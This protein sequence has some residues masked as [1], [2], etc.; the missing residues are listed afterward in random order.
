M[1]DYSDIGKSIE[2]LSREELEHLFDALAEQQIEN[3]EE[4]MSFA[5]TV[6]TIDLLLARPKIPVTTAKDVK[7]I[8]ES[9]IDIALREIINR[10][11][12][13]QLRPL[14]SAISKMA[15]ITG[16][17]AIKMFRPFAHHAVT[18]PARKPTPGESDTA[19]GEDITIFPVRPV[20]YIYDHNNETFVAAAQTPLVVSGLELMPSRVGVKAYTVA[21]KTIADEPV[22]FHAIT[23]DLLVSIATYLSD[24][25]YGYIEWSKGN[26][27]WYDSFAA[28][29]W[30]DGAIASPNPAT[31][32]AIDQIR[33]MH[34]GAYDTPQE[35]PP[36]MEES[37]F[38]QMVAADFDDVPLNSMQA[39]NKLAAYGLIP[40]YIASIY[41]GAD[42]KYTLELYNRQVELHKIAKSRVINERQVL[43]A[44][45]RFSLR[46]QLASKILPP[47][48][49]ALISRAENETM[50]R[51]TLTKK[52]LDQIDT[53]Y[54]ITVKYINAALNN[55]CGHIPLYRAFRKSPSIDAKHKAWDDLSKFVKRV[56]KKKMYECNTC[57]FPL[58]CPHYIDYVKL[59]AINASVREIRD[60]LTTYVLEGSTADAQKCKICY[61]VMF[62]RF[63]LSE[64]ITAEDSYDDDLRRSIYV[65]ASQLIGTIKFKYPV[66]VSGLLAQIRDVVYPYA[67]YIDIDLKHT[68]SFTSNDIAIRRNAYVS[69]VIMAKLVQ[70]MATNPNMYF[71]KAPKLRRLPEL[72]DF[73]AGIIMS[74]KTVVL[75]D[76]PGVTKTVIVDRITLGIS[77]FGKHIDVTPEAERVE[78]PE[79]FRER[80][81]CDPTYAWIADAIGSNKFEKIMGGSPGEVL[82]FTKSGESVYKRAKDTPVVY[83][84]PYLQTIFR[85]YVK[86]AKSSGGRYTQDE[87]A[88][89]T[90]EFGRSIQLIPEKERAASVEWNLPRY[91]AATRLCNNLLVSGD[92]RFKEQHIPIGMVYDENG[93]QHK[94]KL[95]NVGNSTYTMKQLAE[96]AKDK[97]KLA[98]IAPN[99][100]R[101]AVTDRTCKICGVRR[102]VADKLDEARVR[103]GIAAAVEIA[104]FYR[105]YE[106]RCPAGDIHVIPTGATAKRV[107]TKCGMNLEWLTSRSADSL[108]FYR[109][110]KDQFVKDRKALSIRINADVAQPSVKK[111]VSVPQWTEHFTDVTAIAEIANVHPRIIQAFGAFEGTRLEAIIS[112]AYTPPRSERRDDTRVLQV[113]AIVRAMVGAWD[114]IRNYNKIKSHTQYTIDIIGK[115]SRS[116]LDKLPDIGEGY[117]ALYDYFYWNKTPDQT[118]TMCIQEWCSRLLAIYKH[119]DAETA[120]LRTEFV[121]TQIKNTIAG[122]ELFTERQPFNWAIIY[123]NK[124]APDL[125]ENFDPEEESIKRDKL[126]SLDAFDMDGEVE[127]HGDL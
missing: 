26:E 121:K 11:D 48:R 116:V 124:D 43:I 12:K 14:A 62:S 122:Q 30:Q 29:N 53:E 104:A 66:D 36:D 119:N 58:V 10:T 52:E 9:P 55:T 111:E 18:A 38:L 82:A 85:Q 81:K 56:E 8:A 27:R 79:L 118:I 59:S 127:L 35:L 17:A 93:E 28:R 76:I 77:A 16:G 84:S 100:L 114:K 98:E 112:G 20:E 25:V 44:R 83:K 92:Q 33:D 57:G 4:P 96:I 13:T 61:E 49:W 89:M 6:S 45:E 34:V 40:A 86:Y 75:R 90:D 64:D 1:L 46:M 2:T 41:H 65:E 110:K 54:E 103:D 123:G 74:M 39:L 32:H 67:S 88:K 19:K 125:V 47:V 101:G 50:L 7:M 60:T 68:Q 99:G 21:D 107:C 23:K 113:N 31:M 71:E 3:G 42:S 15:K 126:F 37:A 5:L 117:S 78:S 115:T 102:S 69:M 70:L 24:I 97:A 87:L 95:L 108:N 72:I 73:A 63:D 51:S 105:F 94:F 80:I 120:N 106:Q 22:V 109:S 91:R